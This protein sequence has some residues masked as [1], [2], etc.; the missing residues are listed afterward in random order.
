[1]QFQ[2]V[3]DG[4]AEMEKVKSPNKITQIWNLKMTV[5]REHNLSN[6]PMPMEPMD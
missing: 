2:M 1:M 6:L 3:D 4:G 5:N